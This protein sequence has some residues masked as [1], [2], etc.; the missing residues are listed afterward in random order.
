MKTFGL[1]PYLHVADP[2]RSIEFYT[3]LGFRCVAKVGPEERP[4]WAK[5]EGDRGV[6]MLAQ[7]DGKIN[8]GEQAVMLYLYSADVRSLRTSL[9]EAGLADGGVY[10]GGD[11]EPFAPEGTTFEI[12]APSWMPDGEMRLHDPD[13]YVIQV[14]QLREPM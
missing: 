3:K 6:L 2:L 8:A 11:G 14:G 12:I 5:M 1:A 4:V 7:S 13:G 9:L 10:R